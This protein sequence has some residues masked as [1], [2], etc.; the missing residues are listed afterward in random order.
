[1]VNLVKM[2]AAV[3]A[4]VKHFPIFCGDANLKSTAKYFF[5]IT[6]TTVC[7]NKRGERMRGIIDKWGARTPWQLRQGLLHSR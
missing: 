5:F 2:S 7:Q 3:A 6:T 4:P 1:M